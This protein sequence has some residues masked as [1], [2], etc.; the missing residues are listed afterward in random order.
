MSV[1]K[2][3]DAEVANRVLGTNRVLSNHVHWSTQRLDDYH[4]F[5]TQAAFQKCKAHDFFLRAF[6]STPFFHE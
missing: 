6:M 1:G 5:L 2:P 3:I 4:K